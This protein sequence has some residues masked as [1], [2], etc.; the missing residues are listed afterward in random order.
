MPVPGTNTTPRFELALLTATGARAI[1]TQQTG[2]GGKRRHQG[3]WGLH[4]VD[5]RR[6]SVGDHC[7]HV[8]RD[9]Q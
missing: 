4:H 3:S 8:G 2:G 9:S 7:K 1:A 6:H 5:V